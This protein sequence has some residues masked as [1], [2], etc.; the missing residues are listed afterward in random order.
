M[1][2]A[3]ENSWRLREDYFSLSSLTP[4]F[5]YAELKWQMTPQAVTPFAGMASFIAW[6]ENSPSFLRFAVVTI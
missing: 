4:L 3:I 5:G 2:K 1:K 6:L